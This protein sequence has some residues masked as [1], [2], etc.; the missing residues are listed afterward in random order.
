MIARRH[1]IEF[2]TIATGAGHF[3]VAMRKHANL[4]PNA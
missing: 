4:N 3:S 2:G 1:M